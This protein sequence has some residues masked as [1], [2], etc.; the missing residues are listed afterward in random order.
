[1]FLFI[2]EITWEPKNSFIDEDGTENDIFKDYNTAHLI[3]KK[4]KASTSSQSSAPP[5]KK[6]KNQGE[7]SS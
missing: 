4:R 7:K 1:M 2:G 6:T 5:Q 3:K